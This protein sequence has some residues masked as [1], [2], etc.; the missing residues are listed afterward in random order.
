MSGAPLFY[1]S[2]QRIG[3][4]LTRLVRF[5]SNYHPHLPI[6]NIT[7]PPETIFAESPLLFN[8]ILFISCRH[9]FTYSSFYKRLIPPLNVLISEFSADPNKYVIEKGIQ[10]LLLLC[11][12]PPPFEK[13][14]DDLSWLRCGMTTHLALQNG[15]HRPDCAQEFRGGGLSKDELRGRTAIWLACFLADFSYAHRHGLEF[16]EIQPLLI[17]EGFSFIIK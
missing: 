11:S 7:D 5:H 14:V 10:A 17:F 4:R 16:S 15:F 2:S 8:T 13:Q 12:W 6:V 1:L 9:H 3:N